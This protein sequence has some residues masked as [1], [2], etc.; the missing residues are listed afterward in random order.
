MSRRALAMFP[1][2]LAGLVFIVAGRT[3]S[4]E[5]RDATPVNEHVTGPFLQDNSGRRSVGS[6]PIAMS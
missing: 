1:Q 6:S 3:E 2:C 4:A 5:D